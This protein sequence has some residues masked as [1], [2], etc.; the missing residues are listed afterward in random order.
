[1]KFSV[2]L[3]IVFFLSR[4]HAQTYTVSPSQLYPALDIYEVSQVLAQFSFFELDKKRKGS[5]FNSLSD[6]IYLSHVHENELAL[7]KLDLRYEAGGILKISETEF[8]CHSRTSRGRDFA[9]YIRGK[10]QSQFFEICKSFKNER[11]ANSKFELM[12]YVISPAEAANSIC[13]GGSPDARKSIEELR[14]TVD[15][16]AVIEGIG[17]CLSSFVKGAVSSA[18]GAIDGLAQILSNPLELWNQ[19]TQQAIAI[20]NFV[21]H[22]K[23]EVIKIKESIGSL[24]SEFIAQMACH[25]GGEVLMSVG[26][27]ALAGAGAAK[28]ALTFTQALQKI[29]SIQSIFSRLNQLKQL[30]KTH[31]AKEI[32]SCGLKQ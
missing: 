11:A 28:L 27:S 1:M 23:D 20:K 10:T 24:D 13:S 32:L 5:A 19:I 14:R 4:V 25:L 15:N 16:S 30:G 12:K 17:T 3:L 21:L 18:T 22:L 6:Q 8:V 29:K 7:L 9:L 26:L 31:L 2:I